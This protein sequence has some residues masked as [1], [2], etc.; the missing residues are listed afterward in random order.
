MFS[1]LLLISFLFFIIVVYWNF[2]SK[3]A[4]TCLLLTCSLIFISFFSPVYAL[5]YLVLAALTYI[6]GLVIQE[7]THLKKP[8]FIT[9]IAFL[10]INFSFFKYFKPLFDFLSGLLSE[11]IGFP[12]VELPSIVLPLGLSFITF[13]LIHYLVEMGRGKI[14]ET[15]FVD[16]ALYLLFFPL[17]LAGPIERFP[18]FYGQTKEMSSVD[19]NM[20]IDGLWRIFSGIVKKFIFADMFLAWAILVLQNP[21]PHSRLIV[22]ASV[23]GAMIRLYLDFAGYTDI[24]VGISRLFGYRIVENFNRPFFQKN[25]ALFW[26]NWHMS[27]YTWIRDYFYF[28]FFVYRASTLKLYAGPF[29]TIMIFMLWHGGSVNFVLGGL[30]NGLVLVLWVAFQELKRKVPKIQRGL[31]KSFLTPLSV[32]L[33]FSYVCFGTGIFFFTQ[34]LGQVQSLIRKIFL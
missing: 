2:K 34:N 26:R 8:I 25:I 10:I 22:I 18:C 6:S 27:L 15:S 11:F 4:R 31:N 7:N 3:K 1:V 20:I 9:A 32:F 29:L 28:P 12:R 14:K 19:Y 33:T 16:F 30:I 23:Y 24:A 13:R 17:F 21:Q 5:Y